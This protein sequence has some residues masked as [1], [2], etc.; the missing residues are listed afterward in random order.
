MSTFLAFP[1]R[2]L[3]ATALVFFLSEGATRCARVVRIRASSSFSE[4]WET[5]LPMIS[6]S[7]Y[8]VED[9]T[10]ED[11]WL[12]GKLKFRNHLSKTA[13]VGFFCFRRVS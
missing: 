11:M 12:E 4:S 7:R 5:S 13:V 8:G 2:T 9:W 3:A 6:Q 10:G 1:E